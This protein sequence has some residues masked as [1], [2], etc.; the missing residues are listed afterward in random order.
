MHRGAF[1]TRSTRATR[2]AEAGNSITFR[3]S[4][5]FDASDGREVEVRDEDIV[6]ATVDPVSEIHHA[7]NELGIPLNLLAS[8]RE[9]VRFLIF[10]VDEVT[11]MLC[12][13]SEKH[14]DDS[15]KS[16][17][18]NEHQCDA[19]LTTVADPSL[20]ASVQSKWTICSNSGERISNSKKSSL[21]LIST[22]SIVSSVIRGSR[23]LV[24][25]KPSGPHCPFR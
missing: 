24:S 9:P 23:T 12:A 25:W 5:V 6:E 2:A 15:V 18:S 16:P 7:R 19:G 17:K 10:R 1:Y 8:S 11:N 4:P 22:V 14:G 20:G 3:T 21:S 13:V